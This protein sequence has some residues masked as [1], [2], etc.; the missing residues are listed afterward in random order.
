MESEIS[1]VVE[2]VIPKV[3]PVYIMKGHAAEVFVCSWNPHFSNKVAT[4][5]R[6]ATVLIWTVGERSGQPSSD[7][8]P[9]PKPNEQV[10]PPIELRHLPPTDQSDVTSMD[11]NP[12]GTLLATGSYDSVLRIWQLDGEIYLRQ[13]EANRG[14]LFA[15]KFSRTGKLLL[16]ASLDGTACVWDVESKSIYKKFQVHKGCCLDV[17]WLDDDTFASCSADKLIH[18]ISLDST[19]P[20]KTY[21]GHT[22]EINQIKFND[23]RTLL[24]SC[25]DDR[26]ARIWDIRGWEEH[27]KNP[28]SPAVRGG[29]MWTLE[30]HTDS[31]G[32]INWCPSND[33]NSQLVASSSFDCTARLWDALTGACLKVFDGSQKAI[34]TLNFSPKGKYLVTGSG[35]GNMNVYLVKTQEKVWTWYSG[36]PEAGIFEVEWQQNDDG[37]RMC[38]CLENEDV[39]ILDISLIPELQE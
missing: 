27:A 38:I 35:D 20:F 13:E 7:G 2:P 16:S 22:N 25:S 14:P 5:S 8:T 17:D 11:W 33:E 37:Q 4:G 28:Q 21:E 9:P 24:A 12:Q 32:S 26:T 39:G 31:L 19:E 3:D 15:L 30:G 29:A 6:D 18:L 34:F 23:S 10:G 1:E 36:G